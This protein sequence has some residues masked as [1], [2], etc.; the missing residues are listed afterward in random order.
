MQSRT[1]DG[2]REPLPRVVAQPQIRPGK[3]LLEICLDSV[4]SAV[5]SE[6]GG[7]DRV[8]LCAGL[9]EGGTT[10]STGMIAAVRKKISIGMHVMVRP[11]G[12]DFLYSADEFGIMQ[13]D[14]LIAKQLGANGVVFC[15]LNAHGGVDKDRMRQLIEMARPLKVTCHRAFDMSCEMEQALDDLMEVK[16]DSVL[17]SGGKK[18]AVDAMPTLKQLVQQAQGRISVMACGELSIAN[19]KA[20]IAYSGVREVHAGLGTSVSSAMKFRNQRIEM[21]TLA[22]S[23]YQH[24]VVTESSVRELRAAVDSV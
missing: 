8:E 15:I 1:A 16:V 2:E 19:V 10:P 4:E 12:G 5:A 9:S 20:V 3:V 11:R 21:G 17:T 23:E 6:R 18:S 7:A 24:V 14:I 22:N 13:R